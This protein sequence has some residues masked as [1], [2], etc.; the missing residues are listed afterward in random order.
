MLESRLLLSH[1]LGLTTTSLIARRDEI[2]ETALFA[3]LLARRAAGE[4]LAYITGH[5][6]FWS[7]DFLTNP[8]TLIPRA[9]SETL[10]E[11]AL[12]AFAGR[13]APET[14]LDLGTG[15]GCLLLACLSEFPAAWGIGIDRS[16]HSAALAARNAAR[17]GLASRAAFL[18][19]NWAAALA[20]R[21]D[22]ILS[23][24]PY[25]PQ[26]DIPGL[27][28]E[29]AAHEPA[30][31]LDGGADGLDAYRAIIAALPGL[32]S[33]TGIAILELGI[34]QS[35][36]VAALAESVGFAAPALKADLPGIARAMIISNARRDG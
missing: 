15:T 4:P 29:V 9:D 12:G 11:A 8:A 17:L 10:I 23:N 32:L 24:P 33:P 28:R 25:I 21:F 7:L 2:A 5:R 36:A 22:L 18:A 31:A 30:S 6:E 1:A 26:A 16:P 35:V 3:A 27:M 34:G 20:T 14:I 13:P 19:G